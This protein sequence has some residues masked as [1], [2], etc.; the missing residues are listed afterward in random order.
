VARIHE[1]IRRQGEAL[2]RLEDREVRAMLRAY[3]D[4]RRELA[5]DLERMAASGLDR[6][7]PFTAQHLRATMA[8]IEAGAKRMERRLGDVLSPAIGRAQARSLED[9]LQ[10]ISSKER[11]FRDAGGRIEQE[12]LRRFSE[13]R[14]LLLHEHSIQRYGRDV[15][16]R[17]Q[18]ELVV[19]VTRG[20]TWRQVAKRITGRDD[21]VLA[22]MKARGEL[23]VRMELNGAYNDAHLTGIKSAASVLDEAHP[24]DPLGKKADE[25]RDLR[26]HALS[27]VLTGQWQLPNDPFRVSVA[28]V[29][30]EHERLQEQRKARKL[31]PRRLTGTL[32]EQVG[33][34]YVGNN[35]PA[36]YYDRGRIVPW[37]QSWGED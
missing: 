26:N 35:Y 21:S 29:R 2:D 19:G 28:E 22:G 10:V 31:K 25:F 34:Y 36:H 12:V 5:E 1:L 8:Q 6:A 15:V 16:N 20:Q 18:R 11:E 17:I 13:D 30:A 27:R 24:G 4:A 7:T 37:R 32:W 23:I 14:G 9:L 3:D 33:G